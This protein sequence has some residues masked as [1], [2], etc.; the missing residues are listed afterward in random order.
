MAKPFPMDVLTENATFSLR[1]D[2]HEWAIAV[3]TYTYG[4]VEE[5][6]FFSGVLR[7]SNVFGEKYLAYCDRTPRYLRLKG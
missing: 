1:S 2:L 6:I 3:S 5:P 4:V 7:R